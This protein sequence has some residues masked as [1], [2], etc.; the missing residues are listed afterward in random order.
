MGLEWKFIKIKTFTLVTLLEIRNMGKGLFIGL[1]FHHQPSLMLS[2]W[3]IILVVGGAIILMVKA[4]CKRQMEISM[5]GI[6]RMG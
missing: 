1:I 2:L 6:L 4:P 3:S 5:M